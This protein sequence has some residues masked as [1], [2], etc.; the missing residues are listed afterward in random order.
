MCSLNC[1]APLNEI[2]QWSTFGKQNWRCGMF[3]TDSK[4]VTVFAYSD[5]IT[6]VSWFRQQ[7]DGHGGW[8]SL[9]SV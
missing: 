2:S 4:D 1:S 8:K 3:Q 6:V 5:T 9:K 7:D